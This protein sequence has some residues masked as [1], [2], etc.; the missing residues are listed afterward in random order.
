MKFVGSEETWTSIGAGIGA[1]VGAGVGAGGGSAGAKCH[2]VIVLNQI[3]EIKH[4][5]DLFT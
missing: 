3:E 5:R 2:D 4:L 1:G